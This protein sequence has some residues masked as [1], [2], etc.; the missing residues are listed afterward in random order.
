MAEHVNVMPMLIATVAV[1]FIVACCVADARTRRI[2]NVL[3]ASAMLAGL[4]LNVA[5]H[6][7]SGLGLVRWR[8]GVIVL[9]R[10]GA[11]SCDRGPPG[12][13]RARRSWRVRWRLLWW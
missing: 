11:G 8:A 10:E 12:S 13:E 5:Y 6:G 3:S 2:P 4:G 7:V 9:A 1:V